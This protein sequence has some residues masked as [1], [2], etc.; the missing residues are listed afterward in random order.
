MDPDYAGYSIGGWSGATVAFD[1]SEEALLAL[2]EWDEATQ[3][4]RMDKKVRQR[5]RPGRWWQW[6]WR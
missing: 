5:S 4:E 6:W 3:R 2:I 1:T